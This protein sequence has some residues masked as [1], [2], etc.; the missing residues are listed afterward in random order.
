MRCAY[1]YFS[2][3]S[4][5]YFLYMWCVCEYIKHII[6]YNILQ[7]EQFFNVE[8]SPSIRNLLTSTRE[9]SYADAT[10]ISKTFIRFLSLSLIFATPLSI[11]IYIYIVLTAL[12]RI[13]LYYNKYKMEARDLCVYCVCLS[14]KH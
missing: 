7:H 8:S 14:R 5:L 13:D 12:R 1:G 9:C 10:H 4:L 11:S 3:F 6:D 2:S